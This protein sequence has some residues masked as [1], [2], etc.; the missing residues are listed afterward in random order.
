MPKIQIL[1]DKVANQIAAGEVVERPMSVLKEL[2]ENSIDAGA[3]RINIEFRNGGKSFMSIEDNGIGMSRDEALLSLERHA[4]SKIRETGDLDSISTFG[5]RGEALPSIASVS[6]FTLRTK[7]A[8]SEIG[9]EILV[10]GGKYMH[11]RDYGM[12][13]GTK[14]EVSN[15]FQNVPARLKFLKSDNTESAH[16]TRA[17]RLYAVAHPTIAFT[18]FENGREIFRSPA[19]LQMHDRVAAIWGRQLADDLITLVPAEVF[20]MEI[21]GLIGKPGTSRPSRQEMVTIVNGRPVD[22]RVMVYSLVESYHTLIP[23]ARYPLAFLFLTIDPHLVDVNVHPAKREIRFRDESAVRKFLCDAIL[24]T[25]NPRRH[26]NDETP[27][28]VPIR[29]A[30]FHHDPESV[31]ATMPARS[32]DNDDYEEDDSR[33]NPATTNPRDNNEDFRDNNAGDNYRGNAEAPQQSR[34]DNNGG[35]REEKPFSREKIEIGNWRF[36]AKIP[37][38]NIAILSSGNGLIL[39][40]C[41][42][43]RERIQ[44]E[45]I[46]ERFRNEVHV[47]QQ[48]LI[49]EPIELDPLLSDALTRN[50]NTLRAAGFEIEEFGRNFFRIRAIPDWLPQKANVREFV[51]DLVSRI[52]RFPAEF[53]RANIA[54]VTLAKMAGTQAATRDENFDEAKINDLLNELLECSQPNVSPSGQKI[55]VEISNREIAHKFGIF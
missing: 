33:H 41:R 21:S 15:L 14:I 49:A 1:S 22:N 45:K 23:R 42:F 29:P 25:L 20:G 50:M 28:P 47:S 51:R 11:C 8:E 5:F 7:N 18:L 43:A 16:I 53:S 55:F 9:T 37:G 34:G 19:N 36:L 31:V 38:D 35:E 54:H 26:D 13:L 10:N 52:A 44:Y 40:N 39:F 32:N 17:I 3:T 4:T 12:A 48:L 2:L 30:N 46:I 6:H 27:R 24:N